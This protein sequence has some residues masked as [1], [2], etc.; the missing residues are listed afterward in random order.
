[1][2]RALENHSWEEIVSSEDPIKKA[3]L[4]EDSLTS[5]FNSNFPIKKSECL[6]VILRMSPLVKFLPKIRRKNL[7]TGNFTANSHI[8]QRINKLIR[9][10]Q[11]HA[12]KSERQK[13]PRAA[14]KWWATVNSITGRKDSSVPISTILDP[15]DINLYFQEINTDADYSAPDPV[16][17]P[18]VTCVPVLSTSTVQKF[19]LNTKHT[20]SGHDELS[21]WLWRDFADDLAPVVT[22]AFNCSLRHQTAPTSWKYANITPLPKETPLCGLNQLRSISVTNI[23][24]RLFK[25]VV[26]SS[27]L[28][29]LSTECISSDQSAYKKGINSTMA[30]IK[31]QHTW[32]QWLDKKAS[33]VR[34]PSLD[35]SKAFDSVT[36]HIV[37]IKLKALR[38]NP[39]IVTGSLVF[40]LVDYNKYNVSKLMVWK[41]TIYQ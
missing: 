9:E 11:V 29:H 26:Y 3:Q 25:R 30:L 20:S 4:L 16:P 6:A 39:Y 19:L 40:S 23:I 17:I 41:P 33:S 8:Q 12:V 2:S 35:F 22:S 28:F 37:S 38:I 36:H 24:M 15:D 1:M 5:L 34:I 31:C 14:K 7:R 18:D 10:N 32:F 27:K 21:Y 13:H